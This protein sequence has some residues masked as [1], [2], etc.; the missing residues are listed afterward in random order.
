MDEI[1]KTCAREKLSDDSTA[2]LKIVF[3]A[4]RLVTGFSE[5]KVSFGLQIPNNQL[6]PTFAAN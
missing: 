6:S 2:F 1:V 3:K 4:F 5:N